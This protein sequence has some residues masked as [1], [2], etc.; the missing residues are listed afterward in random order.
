[1]NNIPP[2][3]LATTLYIVCEND[4]K[5]S[6]DNVL[7]KTGS[8]N[9]KNKWEIIILCLLLIS[10][11]FANEKLVLDKLHLYNIFFNFLF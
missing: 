8:I 6:I 4:I 1:M 3:Q 7:N 5:K 2:E 10:K 9:W 11:V